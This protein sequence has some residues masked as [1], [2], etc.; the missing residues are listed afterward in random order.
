MVRHRYTWTP[1]PHHR[2]WA[3]VNTVFCP[4]SAVKFG[5]MS[6]RQRDSLTA[7]IHKHEQQ[8]QQQ[9]LQRGASCLVRSSSESPALGQIY[10]SCRAPLEPWYLGRGD[11]AAPPNPRGG[12]HSP[13]QLFLLFIFNGISLYALF[14]HSLCHSTVQGLIPDSHLLSWWGFNRM[15]CGRMPLV[16]VLMF[17][18]V[19]KSS[20]AIR[21]GG[22]DGCVCVCVCVRDGDSSLRLEL[23]SHLS[24]THRDFNLTWTR[25]QKT[26]DLTLT[27]VLGLVNNH[28]VLFFGVLIL[29]KL[30]NVWRA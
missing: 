22:G 23:E 7:E 25:A 19:K 8:Q 20:L 18:E 17:W 27:R 6:K 11:S 29:R 12:S 9:Q 26:S 28:Y 1:T 5:R 16:P 13:L 2:L 21:C 14:S 4:S 24:C 3:Q 15:T 10:L 30:W